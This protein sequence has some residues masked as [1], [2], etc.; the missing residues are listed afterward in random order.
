MG[1]NLSIE[2]LYGEPNLL[3]KEVAMFLT[4]KLILAN[5][6]VGSA[7]LATVGSAALAYALTDSDCRHKLK[8]CVD[9][10]RDCK[11][12]MCN[13]SSDING[14]IGCNNSTTF[15]MICLDMLKALLFEVRLLSLNLCFTISIYQLQ[16]SFH[17]KS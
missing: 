16:N 3:I 2:V 15:F 9:K 14:A 4:K 11:D 13:R 1:Y 7:V 5:I 6:L 10:M 12:Q 17:V 8:D